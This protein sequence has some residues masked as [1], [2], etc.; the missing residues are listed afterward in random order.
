MSG[1]AVHVWVIDLDQETVVVSSLLDLLSG[2]ERVRAARLRTTQSRLRYIVAHGATRAVLARYVDSDPGALRFGQ[3]ASG[4]PHLID[5]VLAFNVAYSEDLGV[6]AVTTSGRLGVDIERVRPPEDADSIARRYF[7][8]TE[9]EEYGSAAPLD[10]P[11]TFFSIWTR[12][13]AFLKATDLERQHRLGS[14]AVDS[15][16]AV[17]SPHIV[18]DEPST[19]VEAGIRLRSFLPR[20]GYVGSVALD[21]E[22]EAL[23]L[24]EWTPD[25]TSPGSSTDTR[26]PSRHGRQA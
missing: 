11:A 18:L 17:V 20:A 5:R 3:A 12:K 23:E 1:D 22:I 13:E 10:K 24:Y 21:R 8:A 19:A 2:E 26:S 9:I 7:A 4:K 14:F 15:K 6:C 16:P 25:L